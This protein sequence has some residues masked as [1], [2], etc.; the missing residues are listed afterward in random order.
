MEPQEDAFEM[1]KESEKFCPE[2]QPK[3]AIPDTY[4]EFVKMKEQWASDMNN[5]L[6]INRKAE[7]KPVFVQVGDE[8]DD[9]INTFIIR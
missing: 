3:I 9:S 1:I 8:Y 5:F 4:E 2:G 6:R 7:E